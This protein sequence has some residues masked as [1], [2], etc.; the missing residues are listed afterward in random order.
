MLEE[1]TQSGSLNFSI[2][3]SLLFQL[4]EQLVA[5]PSIALTELVKNVYDADATKVTI[6]LENV[7]KPGGTII[8]EDDGH[9][10][11]LEEI[12]NNWMRIATTLKKKKPISRIYGRPL[13]GAKGI[14]RLA[15]RRLGN[16][17]T[18]QS[19]AKRDDGVKEA[20]SVE[21]DWKNKF[22]PGEDLGDVS[23]NF[24]R[25]ESS[26]Q[27]VGDLVFGRVAMR[28]PQLRQRHRMAFPITD[29]LDDR[30]PGRPGHVCDHL[31]QQDAHLVQR[32]LHVLDMSH[33]R[34]NQRVPMPLN[35]AD[36]TPF[37][38]S[39]VHGRRPGG[40]SRLPC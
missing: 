3:S 40:Y 2:D 39:F 35:R 8:V 19:I 20:I 9:G 14:G 29:L 24:T 4:G 32:S 10:M 11:T 23:V 6:T 12:K 5:K 25:R 17:L 36:L 16:K 7:D 31:R 33:V 38:A 1:S 37:M 27:R 28:I 30:Q 21:F 18:L 26:V 34:V 15:D 22:S 13:T